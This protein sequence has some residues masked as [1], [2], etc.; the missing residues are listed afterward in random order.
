MERR[1][2]TLIEQ[3]LAFLARQT[4]RKYAPIVVGI[5]GSVG[6]S[7][8]KEA[9]AL[10]LAKHFSVRASVGNY[11]N[12]LGVPLTILGVESPGHHLLGWARL[13][14]RALANLVWRVRYPEVLILEMGIDRP[15]DMRRHLTVVTPTISVVTQISGSHLEFFGTLG[16]IAKEKGYLV[17]ALPEDGTAILNAD[18]ERVMKMAERTKGKVLTYGFSATAQVRAE[19]VQLLQEGSRIDGM[20]FKLSY[21]GKSVPM[22][23]PEMIGKHHLTAILAATA[24]GLAFKENLIDIAEALLS[25][26]T[27]PGRLTLLPGKRGMRLIDDTYNA[28]VASTESALDVLRELIAPRRVVILGDMLEIG[29]TKLGAHRSLAPAVIGSGATVF[30]GVGKYMQ[31]LADA[32]RATAFPE[33]YIFTFPD[34]AMAANA[35]PDILRPGDLVLV[36]GSQG[37]RMETIVQLLLDDALDPADTLCRQSAGWQRKPFVPPDEWEV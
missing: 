17:S 28:S 37:L 14:L 27:P 26:R 33:K 6:K 32:L 35:L 10:V 34:P 25:F 23:L 13:I 1:M 16:A 36:K 8:T 12:E 4:V 9:V 29:D 19:H 5:T 30:V 31:A 20:S 3:G 15:G 7:S 18:D 11:N 2:K 24:V 22:R 21:A